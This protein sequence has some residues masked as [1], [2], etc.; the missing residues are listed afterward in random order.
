[1]NLPDI[2]YVVFFLF[3]MQLKHLL[4]DFYL[5]TTEMVRGKGQYANWDGIK[6]SLQHGIGTFLLVAIFFLVIG[7]RSLPI[8][9][10]IVAFAALFDFITHYHIDW[11]KMNYGN[12]DI[13]NEQFWQHLGLDQYAHQVVYLLLSVIVYSGAKG[14]LSIP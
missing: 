8:F 2:F 9:L 11:V 7:V 4:V 10:F 6:H 13:A 3:F 1:M 5:Q 12:R 14:M